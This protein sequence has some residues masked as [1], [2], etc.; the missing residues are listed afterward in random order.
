MTSPERLIQQAIISIGN[1]PRYEI[2]SSAISDD[3]ESESISKML[4]D[5]DEGLT[6][7]ENALRA[8]ATALGIKI[9]EN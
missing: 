9:Q 4:Q 8:A 7:A 5:Y 1:L 3:D 6:I 2:I